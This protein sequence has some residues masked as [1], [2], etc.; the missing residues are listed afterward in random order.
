MALLQRKPSSKDHEKEN[1]KTLSRNKIL[2]SIK[3]H[4]S[5]TNKQ[6]ITGN[7]P[8]LDI[9]NIKAYT[10]FGEILSICSPDF[11]WKQNSDINQRAITLLQINKK[12]Q[13]KIPY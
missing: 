11:E 5:V 8:N 3:G 9:F 10:K 6:K 13:L 1:L 7:N 2:T 4:N 12:G